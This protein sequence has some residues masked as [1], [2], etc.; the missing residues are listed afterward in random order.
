MFLGGLPR[1]TGLREGPRQ[2]T[3]QS[4]KS[5][6]VDQVE[7]GPRISTAVKAEKGG[8]TGERIQSC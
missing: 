3:V 6:T 4:P 1:Q 8:G 5:S 2:S 7:E